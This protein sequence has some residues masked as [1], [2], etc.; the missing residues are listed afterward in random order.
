VGD[1]DL[2]VATGGDNRVRFVNASNG[3]IARDFSG[4]ADY[5][6]SGAAS[7]DGKTILAGG[8]DSVLR[9]WTDQGAEF[10]KFAAPAPPAPPPPQTAAK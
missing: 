6:Y 3:G 5:M 1:S 8:L 4:T 2:V 9:V 10:A 7:A